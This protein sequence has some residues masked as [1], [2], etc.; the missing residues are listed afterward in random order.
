MLEE[1]IRHSNHNPTELPLETF[2]AHHHF[3]LI[4]MK[5]SNALMFASFALA[6]PAVEVEVRQQTATGVVVQS[7]QTVLNTAN[8]NVAAIRKLETRIN[9]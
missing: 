8:T 2:P 9:D 6:A 1:S 7:V 5:F 3:N 4:K